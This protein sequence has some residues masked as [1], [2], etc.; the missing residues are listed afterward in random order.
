MPDKDGVTPVTHM[1]TLQL[2]PFSRLQAGELSQPLSPRS[3]PGRPLGPI[4]AVARDVSVRQR[5][6]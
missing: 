6:W 3:L 4:S 2:I 5:R 1:H